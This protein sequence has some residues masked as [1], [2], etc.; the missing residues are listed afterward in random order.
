MNKKFIYLIVFFISI[1]L[2]KNLNAEEEIIK[3]KAKVVNSDYIKIDKQTII[4]FGVEAME[5]PQK[6]YINN[7][8]WPCWE[9]GV[10]K[11]EEIVDLGETICFVKG[12]AK[13]NRVFAICETQN[14]EL[15]KELIRSG[16]ALARIK[17][18]D[19]YIDD[20]RYAKE[21][22][23]GIWRGKFIEPWKWRMQNFIPD[24]P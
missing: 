14:I 8:L 22:K 2:L 9:S 12:K 17:Q 24:D 16:L 11:L 3:G 15:N 6:C 13:M 20:E 21:N 5:R 7:E 1:F 4:L 23:L 19:L 18:S 10:R